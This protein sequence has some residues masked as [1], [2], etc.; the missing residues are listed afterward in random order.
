MREKLLIM[1]EKAI[2]RLII[3]FT[4]FLKK[5]HCYSYYYGLWSLVWWIGNYCKLSTCKK[6][7]E[8]RKKNG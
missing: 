4:D 1:Q 2:K 3:V 6:N 5:C 8:I 7:A